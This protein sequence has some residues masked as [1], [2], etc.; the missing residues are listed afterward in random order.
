MSRFVQRLVQECK[1]SPGKA[2]VLGVLLI[3]GLWVC[4]PESNPPAPVQAV[5]ASAADQVPQPPPLSFWRQWVQQ[6]EQNPWK[7]P[8]QELLPNMDVFAP[9]AQQLVKQL[10]QSGGP[11]PPARKSRQEV[12]PR[13]SWQLH[14]VCLG[15]G[16]AVAL[17]DGRAYLPGDKLRWKDQEYTLRWITR[18]GVELKNAQG[19]SLKLKLP[20]RNQD[21][22]IRFRRVSVQEL[23]AKN[24]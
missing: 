23:P 14:G 11:T 7:H 24:S 9:V 17:I 19:K 20:R 4:W 13:P 21:S 22:P 18:E 2:T 5:S 16:R 3:V 10:T 6:R 12:P 15:R 1:Q 8:S